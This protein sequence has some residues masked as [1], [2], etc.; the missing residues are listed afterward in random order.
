MP[1][2][3]SA[4]PG[5]WAVFP[6]AGCGERPLG[7]APAEALAKVPLVP[8]VEERRGQPWPQHEQLGALAAR[9][10]ELL[11]QAEQ[12]PGGGVRSHTPPARAPVARRVAAHQGRPG[13]HAGAHAAQPE[14]R[15][16]GQARERASQVVLG[17]A[18]REA[19]DLEDDRLAV[20]D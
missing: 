16:D 13:T 11:L 15:G 3:L 7:S 20:V 1:L 19:L 10:A 2:P 17:L 8:A 12:Q 4:C 14:A 9:R 6:L 5:A 18:P